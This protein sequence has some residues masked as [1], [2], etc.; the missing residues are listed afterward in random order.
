[1]GAF[2]FDTNP[3]SE[4]IGG[5]LDAASNVASELPRLQFRILGQLCLVAE[6]LEAAIGVEVLPEPPETS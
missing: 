3:D 5:I 2:L 6:Q 1:M 4:D